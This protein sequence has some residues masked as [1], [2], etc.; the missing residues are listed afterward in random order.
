MQLPVPKLTLLFQVMID[1]HEMFN[2]LVV[3]WL[4]DGVNIDHELD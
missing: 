2:E 1:I 3:R 4:S